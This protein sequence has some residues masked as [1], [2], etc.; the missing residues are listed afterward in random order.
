MT[1]RGA[2]RMVARLTRRTS[3]CWTF[4]FAQ[5][6]RAVR[7]RLKEVW[8]HR[9]KPA[10]KRFFKAALFSAFVASAGPRPEY[11]YS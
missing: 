5:K 10:V 1:G 6:L 2:S 3:L 9:A 7:G 11:S 4:E 8:R